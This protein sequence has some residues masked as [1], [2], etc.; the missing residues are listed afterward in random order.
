MEQKSLL[1]VGLWVHLNSLGELPVF[2]GQVLQ[3]TVSIMFGVAVR[4][5]KCR[6]STDTASLGAR[7]TI[8]EKLL[9]ER[10]VPREERVF[11]ANF[12]CPLHH[13]SLAPLQLLS[14][15]PSSKGSRQVREREC[16]GRAVLTAH[17]GSA[18]ARRSSEEPV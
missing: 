4:L 14:H 5:Q 3:P 7:P 17:A 15:S 1:D 8:M 11:L 6:A 16:R 10:T 18:A 13:Y 9:Q 12:A 2:I